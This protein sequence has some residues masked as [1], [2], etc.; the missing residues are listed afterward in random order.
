MRRDPTEFR[1]R[2]AAWKDGKK[3]YEAGIPYDDDNHNLEY[4]HARAAELGYKP[5]ETGHYPTRDYKTGRYLKSPA[6]PTVMKSVVSDLGEGYIPYYN[7]GQLYSNT[8]MKPY[9]KEDVPTPYRYKDGKLP[10]YKNGLDDTID[11][12]KQHEGFRDTT[13]LDGNGIPT[14]GYGFTDSSLVKKGKITQAE[15]DRQLRREILKRESA[16]SKLKNW[17][18]LSEGSKVALRSYYY[19]YPAGFKDTTK[20]MQYWNAG[21][22]N[23]AIREVDAGM[24]DKKNRGLRAR[25][26]QEQAMLRQDPFLT[27]QVSPLVR[28]LEEQPSF[29][30]VQIQV[31]VDRIDYSLQNASMQSP[32]PQTINAWRGKGSPAYGGA[33]VRMPSLQ[34][35]MQTGNIMPIGFKNGKSPIYIKPSNRGKLTELKKRTGKS[36]EEL[37]NDGNPAHKKMVV[38]A[39]NARKW[40]H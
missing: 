30:P 5:D 18:K 33:Y 34:E 20:F 9:K 21:D 2:F 39:R 27:R 19:N 22:Y 15:A 11:F 6:H 17:D 14:I 32:A 28:Q 36:E 13:Y 40:K 3:P 37:Y 10:E 12:L 26:L 8:W 35:Y 7:N 1:K 29:Q 4:D 38:F 31:P 16:L 25:R 24:N 23:N